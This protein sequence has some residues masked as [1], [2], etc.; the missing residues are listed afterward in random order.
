MDLLKIL[1]SEQIKAWDQYTISHQ[2]ITSLELMERAAF[3]CAEWI[4]TSDVFLKHHFKKVA[5]LCGRGNNGGDGL[6]I[7]RLLIDKGI[8]VETFI[9]NHSDNASSDFV[10]NLNRL[11]STKNSSIKEIKAVEEFLI[12]KD[13]FFIDAILGSGIQRPVDGVI[14]DII[15]KI[16][17]SDATVIS[18]DVPTGMRCDIQEKTFL[19]I[20]A[21]VT[22][23]FQLPKLSMLFPDNYQ[24]TGEL[25]I[26]NIGLNI[27][28]NL[29]SDSN[30]YFTTLDYVKKIL[31]ARKK[32][33]HKGTYG[34]SLLMAG[35]YGK[36]GAA[37]LASKACLRSGTGVLTVACTKI[38]TEIMQNSVPA[39]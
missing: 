24:F 16:N 12:E 26:L 7:S 4:L 27:D 22:V 8:F 39:K 10:T 14:F 17:A 2:S 18:I 3:A 33:D 34:H 6:A 9:I 5:I 28:F 13:V 32:F 15:K 20:H 23:T 25:I 21:V 31:K 29:K 11:K 19:A 36:M 37:V 1:T 38:G 30:Y 35:S